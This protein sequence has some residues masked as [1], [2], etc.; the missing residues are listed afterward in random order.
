MKIKQKIGLFISII[1]VLSILVII[2]TSFSDNKSSVI[3]NVIAQEASGSCSGTDNCGNFDKEN[4]C[5]DKCACSWDSDTSEC[6]SLGCSSCSDQT[7]CED[8][9]CTWNVQVITGGAVSGGGG[10][11]RVVGI[12]PR[13]PLDADL[14]PKEPLQ[15]KVQVYYAGDPTN[16][17]KVIANSTM[18]GEVKLKHE[19]GLDK[20]IYIA[21]VII[22]K[23]VALGKQRITYI[24]TYSGQF[25]EISILIEV[26]P[27]LNINMSLNE[28]YFKG[29]KI[30][31]SGT[32]LDF[33][34]TPKNK[35][36]V[37][38]SGYKENK[39]FNVFATTNES[40]SFSTDYFIKYADPEGIWDIIVEAVSLDEK[41]AMI[42]FSPKI[43]IPENIVYYSVN[44]LS[45]LKDSLFRR[46]DA[47]SISVEVKEIDKLIEKANVIF[48]TPAGEAITLEEVSLGVYSGNYVV[49]PDDVI[50][51]WLLKAEASTDVEFKKVGGASLPIKISST[52]I[53][54]NQISPETNVIYTNSR[55]KIKIKLNYPDGSVVK[56]SIV[57]AFLSND[58]T[59]PL[60]ETS[61]GIY[62]GNYFVKTKDVGTLKVEINAEDVDGN[63][64]SLKS[65][66]FIRKRTIIGNVIAYPQEVTK[67]YWG[68]ILVFLIAAAF[69][70]RPTFEIWWINRRLKKSEQEQKK[71]KIMQLE[72]EKKYYKEGSITKKELGELMAEYEA[73]LA[74]ARENQKVYEK[75]LIE[76]I[77]KEKR[78]IEAKTRKGVDEK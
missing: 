73:R 75:A 23:N 35:A 48:Y 21:N 72:T 1:L 34:E 66:F 33:S 25:D 55:L 50:G 12:V 44:F 54:F 68:F 5:N 64:G 77:N 11:Q 28:N 58:E 67:K 32:I 43:N 31:F 19:S 41:S 60:L 76:K 59:L 22:G 63:F 27:G 4:Q 38:I 9:A 24:A 46:G 20:G 57:N 3:G 36:I 8:S 26:V 30:Q 40:G 71:I 2:D 78:K 16:T 52:E 6:T 65:V 69:I 53:I 15:L 49:K 42:K 45:P 39:I 18:F 51:G 7:T 13:T 62:E 17:A 56:G 74:K 37:T 14:I 10:V 61:N 29:N 47:I 70:Y